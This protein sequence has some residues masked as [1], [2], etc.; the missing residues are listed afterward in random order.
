M[1]KYLVI[2]FA[3]LSL[4]LLSVLYLLNGNGD[5]GRTTNE[6]REPSVTELYG[7]WDVQLKNSDSREVDLQFWFFPI[8]GFPVKDGWRA[9]LDTLPETERHYLLGDYSENLDIEDLDSANWDIMSIPNAPD[10]RIWECLPG[11]QKA[12]AKV[13]IV[14]EV[15]GQLLRFS[16]YSMGHLV[17][18]SDPNQKEAF[19]I[20]AGPFG[21]PMV[22]QI[23]DVA[24]PKRLEKELIVTGWF[25][26]KGVLVHRF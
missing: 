24:S 16:D 11:E 15:D 25:K 3:G 9:F 17:Q 6:K 8:S 26:G 5:D 2:C 21:S 22:F 14:E 12:I 20:V 23:A 1:I 13:V 19:E 7:I 4:C 18:V 10:P